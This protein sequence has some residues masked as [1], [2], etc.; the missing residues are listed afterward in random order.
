VEPRF[1]GKFALVT[2]AAKGMGRQTAID[3]A[4]EGASVVIADIDEAARQLGPLGITC[5]AIAPRRTTSP[6]A[7]RFAAWEPSRTWPP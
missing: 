3:M 7:S 1:V 6:R 5:N 4:R 2:G